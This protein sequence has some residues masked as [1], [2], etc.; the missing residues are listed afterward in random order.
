MIY[1]FRLKCLLQ[2]VDNTLRIMADKK[3]SHV[4]PDC[5]IKY[6][7][8]NLLNN[9]S[10]DSITPLGEVNKVQITQQFTLHH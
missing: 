4:L 7:R 8:A 1:L 10:I 9:S 6:A 3:M 2:V 5:H